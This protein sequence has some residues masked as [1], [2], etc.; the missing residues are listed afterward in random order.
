[1]RRL[2]PDLRDIDDHLAML[3]A[4]RRIEREQRRR[5]DDEPD[6]D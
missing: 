3:E 5:E 1:V 6:P 4:L 2:D